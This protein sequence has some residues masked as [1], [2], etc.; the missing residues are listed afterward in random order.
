MTRL[1]SLPPAAKAAAP[2]AP[3]RVLRAAFGAW[4]LLGVLF[5][6]LAMA[7]TA[8]AQSGDELDPPGRAGRL[9]EVQGKVWLY[10]TEASEWVEAVRNRPLTT[11]DRI[12][13]ERGGRAE[14]RV[15]STA[16]RIDEGSEL[17]ISLLD[18]DHLHLQLHQ[19]DVAVRL[20]TR[21]AANEFELTTAEGRF[22]AERA[23]TYRIGRDDDTSDAT[24]VNGL[25]Q[26]RAPDAGITV[27]AGQRYEIWS[28]NGTQYQLTDVRRDDFA[29]WIDG[30]DQREERSVSAKYASAEMTGIEDLD[31]YGRWEQDAE[32]GPLWIPTTVASGWAPYR[33]GHWAWVSPW[34]WTWVDDAPWG[35]AP[36]H[37]G[38]WV[39]RHNVWCWSPGRYVPRPV[40]APALVAWIGGPGVSVS[41]GGGRRPPNVGWFPLG[42]REVYVPGYR[43]SPHYM[44]AVNDNQV[45]RGFNLNPFIRD[46]HRAVLDA[47]YRHRNFAPAVTIV[48]GRV[49]ERRQPVAPAI[50]GIGG[51]PVPGVDRM[52]PRPDAPVRPIGR[53]PG[54]DRRPSTMPVPAA[55]GSQAGRSFAERIPGGFRGERGPDRRAPDRQ[56][57]SRPDGRPDARPDQR[58][59]PRPGVIR[60][61]VP[62]ERRN[63]GRGDSFFGRPVRDAAPVRND[64]PPLPT[65]R[66]APPQV[67]PPQP[68]AQPPQRDHDRGHF[69]GRPGNR[70]RD[71]DAGRPQRPPQGQPEVRPP[72]ERPVPAPVQ[73]AP[74]PRVFHGFGGGGGGAR[75]AQPQ[76]VQPAPV[77]QPPVQQAPPPPVRQPM[78]MQ[79]RPQPAPQPPPAQQAPQRE[80]REQRGPRG[81]EDGFPRHRQM[82]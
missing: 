41:I 49:L 55:P 8:W 54:A 36:F 42:P 47:H 81:G 17:E 46:P 67:Q 53:E 12:S 13:T 3:S 64:V 61:A 19:G 52:R 80:Q 2:V 62:E 14:V 82:N 5:T 68:V 76:P 26:V 23:G 48:P 69:S 70:D 32:Q 34:G 60:P 9:S 18:D 40:Y 44:R 72:V 39:H 77:Q 75:P 30:R 51:R 78:V 28:E 31:R 10:D 29:E 65:V 20:R 7:P 71:D 16:I 6:L 11:G 63:D 24:T 21:E 66:P 22:K 4:M 43:F 37:Y 33:A 38:R 1:F 57:G 74:R 15:G 27:K 58:A 25:L 45:P 73:E 79:P 59:D 56:P 35:F 50:I